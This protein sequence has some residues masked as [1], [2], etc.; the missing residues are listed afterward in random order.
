MIL[1]IDISKITSIN[2]IFLLPDCIRKYLNS[3]Q[4]K[5]SRLWY[6]I[7]KLENR[8]KA[9]EN[10]QFLKIGLKKC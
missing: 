6:A 4:T 9:N 7:K 8:L 2:L 1:C 10:E 3:G 5:R